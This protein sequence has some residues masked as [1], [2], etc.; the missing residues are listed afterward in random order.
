MKSRSIAEDYVSFVAKTA[1]PRAMNCW[2][3]YLERYTDGHTT[4]TLTKSDCIRP[5]GPSS[6]SQDE[7][8]TA[9]ESM[10]AGD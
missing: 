2:K 7:T 10:V 3:D 4:E 8:T 9:Y 5:R 1:I 6:D